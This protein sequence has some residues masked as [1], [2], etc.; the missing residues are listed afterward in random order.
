LSLTIRSPDKKVNHI[1]EELHKFG[2]I[3]EVFERGIGISCVKPTDVR[4]DNAVEMSA[5]VVQTTRKEAGSNYGKSCI[6][7]SRGEHR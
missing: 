2:R 3:T 1:L 6:G 7:L 5:L 4:L